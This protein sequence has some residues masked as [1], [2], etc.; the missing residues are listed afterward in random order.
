M[1]NQWNP[2]RVSLQQLHK[3][4]LPPMVSTSDGEHNK[5]NGV[6]MT[7]ENQPVNEETFDQ[8]A[9]L[10]KH[11]T[12]PSTVSQAYQSPHWFEGVPSAR[13]MH[14]VRSEVKSSLSIGLLTKCTGSPDVALIRCAT[15]FGVKICGMTTWVW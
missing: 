11:D 1:A 6:A 7:L 2:R 14:Q 9:H 5:V 4:S 10:T 13:S 3:I 12:V 8:F 15:I